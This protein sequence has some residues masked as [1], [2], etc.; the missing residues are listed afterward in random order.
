M[1][2]INKVPGV[3]ESARE[4]LKCQSDGGRYAVL[5]VYEQCQKCQSAKDK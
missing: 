1:S 3:L 5:E 4:V 2:E